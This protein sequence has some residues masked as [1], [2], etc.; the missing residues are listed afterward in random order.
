MYSQRHLVFVFV[1][2]FKQV[3]LYQVALYSIQMNGWWMVRE[4]TWVTVALVKA[5]TARKI[6]NKTKKEHIHCSNLFNCSKLP[7][8]IWNILKELIKHNVV[9]F[10]GK[11]LDL[12][13][14]QISRN[15]KHFFLFLFFTF[16]PLFTSIYN[17]IFFFIHFKSFYVYQ[18]GLLVYSC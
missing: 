5:R 14:N 15:G 3:L 17:F 4:K 13:M 9:W 10:H 8:Y 2:V 6:Q 16:F 7:L 1:F 18:F 12:R 11:L